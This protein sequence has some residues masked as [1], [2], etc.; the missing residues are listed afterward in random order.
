MYKFFFQFFDTHIYVHRRLQPRVH[1]RPVR[2]RAASALH[3]FDA[4]CPRDDRRC[5]GVVY[6]CRF[7]HR[8]PDD[9]GRVQGDDVTV[10]PCVST[11]TV[12]AGSFRF[13]RGVFFVVTC[14]AVPIVVICFCCDRVFGAI[15]RYGSRMRPTTTEP[16]AVVYAH[17]RRVAVTLVLL[18][19]MLVVC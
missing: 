1:C 6:S 4:R 13:L 3:M 8:Q 7:A 14:Y 15:R 2:P 11:T 10:W 19:F 17:Q 12:R 18:V 5:L 9:N 16:E